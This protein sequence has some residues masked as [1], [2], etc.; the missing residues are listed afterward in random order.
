MVF[1]ITTPLSI[2]LGIAG[3]GT[4][5]RGI[6]LAALLEGFPVLLYDVQA[7]I[8]KQ[9]SENILFYLQRKNKDQ[10]HNRLQL[11]SRL[12][13]LH[14]CQIV[15][16]AAPENLE[17]KQDLFIRLDQICPP[18]AI[19]ATNTSSLSI[20]AI[21]S[22]TENPQ[23]VLGMHFFNPPAVL[24]LV[25]VVN[26]PSTEAAVMQTVVE[27]AR[28]IGKTP[29]VVQDQP[30]FIVNRVA[31]PFYGEAYRLLG[32]GAATIEQIDTLARLGGGFRMGPFELMDLIG[33]DINYTAM[34][35][36]YEQTWGEPR[37]RP[38]R[39]Q[40]QKI[41]QNQLGRKT[42]QGFYRYS[43]SEKGFIP[44]AVPRRRQGEGEILIAPG[45][46]S[47]GL[48]ALLQEN[49]YRVLD[50]PGKT[51]TQPGFAIFPAGKSEN[52]LDLVIEWDRLLPPEIPILVQSCDTNLSTV[53]NRLDHPQRL[54][55]FDGLF[56]KQA[57]AV[58]LVRSSLM[59]KQVEAQV[60]QFISRLGKLPVWIGDTPGLVL[61]RLVSML[62]NEAAFAVLE[63]AAD[64]E[65]IDLAMRL[66]V[67]YPQGPLSWAVSL[68]LERVLA[69]LD[70][71]FA[72][73]HE[74]RYRAAP[75]LRNW[76]RSRKPPDFITPSG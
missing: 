36:M 72:E 17:L 74:E 12:D 63:G 64:P 75:N 62:T 6:A 14:T 54:A 61:P 10:F 45:S 47:P 39:L 22:V 2:Q 52:M 68:G 9:A 1:P 20:T 7:E 49:G 19:L 30:G 55:G 73:Y 21:A 69:I 40:R 43:G 18:P 27:L 28:K 38:H 53:E 48:S 31:R 34:L 15:I 37:Y 51:A 65:T 26:H 71:L 57:Q 67:N 35:S 3:A 33:I 66:G 59:D 50:Q 25:E 16:E 70:H 5:G 29:V 4:M 24:P 23:R 32:E 58:S 56:F 13:D 46:W 41:E 76:V 60:T 42:G 44:P 11:T 8:L